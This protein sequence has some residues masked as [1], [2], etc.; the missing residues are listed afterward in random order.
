VRNV[1]ISL[2]D[3]TALWARMEAARRDTSVSQ[4]VGNLLRRQMRDDEEYARASRSYSRRSSAPL[5][6]A[7]RSY[8][9]RD[10]VHAR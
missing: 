8:P 4:F 10:E 5:S 2:D 9:S 1:T 7:G 6:A 3:E